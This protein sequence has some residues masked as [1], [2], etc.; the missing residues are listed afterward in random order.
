MPKNNST[1]HLLVFVSF[2]LLAA[3]N[4]RLFWVVKDRILL[5]FGDFGHFYAAALIVRGGSGER[6]YD[7]EEQRQVQRDLFPDVDTRPEPLIFNHLAYETLLWWPLTFS[8]YATAAVLWTLFNLLVLVVL[9]IFL[10]RYFPAA[11]GALHVPWILPLLA[12]FPILIVLIQGQDSIV[13]LALYALTFILLKRDRQVLAGCIL[14]LGLFKF[15]LVL[16][17]VGF[18]LL[19]RNW[20]FVSGFAAGSIVPIGISL[21]ITGAQGLLQFLRFLLRSNQGGA[22][23]EQFGLY[24]GSMPNIRGVLFTIFGGVL[25][26]KLLFSLTAVLSVAVF[27]W[28]VQAS[29]R[30]SLDVRCGLA[31]MVT[32]LV[33]Y[34]LFVYD[35]A[36]AVLPLLIIVDRMASGSTRRRLYEAS[37]VLSGALLLTTPVHLVI[38]SYGLTAS[39]LVIPVCILALL[40]ASVGRFYPHREIIPH[41]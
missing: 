10:T 26:N 8:P 11:W 25:S 32:L 5:G 22:S 39:Y 28:A 17:F 27:G 12:C 24:P 31:I 36:I 19:Q 15:Q 16:P 18:F 1:T 41:Y 9:S 21:W 2:A 23:P 20:K 35:L 4:V 7:Y 29:R 34:H 30:S 13:L 3:L 6:L 38:L 37:L 33:S 40:A 14:A